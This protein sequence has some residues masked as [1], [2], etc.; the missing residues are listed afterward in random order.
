MGNVFTI[1][2]IV[3]ACAFAAGGLYLYF[4]NV[5]LAIKYFIAGGAISTL[6]VLLWLL[7]HAYRWFSKRF[8]RR[9]A[10]EGS[11]SVRTFPGNAKLRQAL[12]RLQTLNDHLPEEDISEHDVNDYHAL[13]DIVQ[14][15]IGH[16]LNAFRIPKNKMVRHFAGISWEGAYHGNQVHYSQ[17]LFCP[18]ADF[19]IALRSA[20]TFIDSCLPP[21]LTQ[22]EIKPETKAP[23]MGVPEPPQLQTSAAPQPLESDTYQPDEMERRILAYL[24][25]GTVNR[26]LGSII[27]A[28]NIA[29][30]EEAKFHLEQLVRHFYVNAPPRFRPSVRPN[31]SLRQKGR[32]FVLQN[33]LHREEVK[34]QPPEPQPLSPESAEV[35]KPDE[36]AIKILKE[37]SK[38][39]GYESQIAEVLKL[40]AV[41]VSISLSLLNQHDFIELHQLENRGPYY[42]LTKKGVSRL[43]RPAYQPEAKTETPETQ[44]RPAPSEKLKTTHRQLIS[45]RDNLSKG[46]L[47]ISDMV[48][49]HGLLDT[50][51]SELD[52]DLSE[53]RVPLSAVKSRTGLPGTWGYNMFDNDPTPP[54][55]PV[56]RYIPSE[57]FKSKLDA[58]FSHLERP[59]YNLPHPSGFWVDDTSENI[60]M[61]I[62]DP[63]HDNDAESFAATLRLHPERVKRHLSELEKHGYVHELLSSLAPPEYT[64]TD[65]GRDFLMSKGHF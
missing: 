10:I 41:Q 42:R 14:S 43:D 50:L 47:H 53:Y 34:P 31:Y 1:L 20:L 39:N 15:E 3:A 13:L 7:D 52:C 59:V 18:R 11:A 21:R 56:E 36:T 54:P 49:Y 65:K 60:L 24:F 40:N 37:I 22:K 4:H 46:E 51:E 27:R 44:V 19:L 8:V 55:V 16:D 57:V 9:S 28:L 45:F 29:S 62:A 32:E 61:L 17:E 6:A 63:E 35:Y 26:D 2:G 25:K 23:E 64:L 12:I 5:D 33:N 30:T 48:E 58:L 38:G